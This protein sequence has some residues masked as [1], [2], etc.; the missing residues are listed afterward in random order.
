MF[1]ENTCFSNA[2][3]PLKK[4]NVLPPFRGIATTPIRARERRRSNES[5]ETQPNLNTARI[6]RGRGKTVHLV[7]WLVCT[8]PGQPQELLVR[9]ETR[10]SLP[11][12]PSL[13]RPAAT[14]PGL[15]PRVSGGTASTAMQC[16]R[17]LHLGGPRCS[18]ISAEIFKME[19]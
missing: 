1:S 6:Q 14:E 3:P 11:A 16:L 15:E 17:P 10:I 8:V 4:K 9:D 12:K 19:S 7:T 5:S 18:A 13:T 2:K